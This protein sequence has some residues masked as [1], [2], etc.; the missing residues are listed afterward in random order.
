M[1]FKFVLRSNKIR[2]TDPVNI[3]TIAIL[4][5][6]EEISESVYR[7]G[8]IW[9]FWVI[10]KWFHRKRL[11]K[12]ERTLLCTTGSCVTRWCRCV[13]DEL[14]CVSSAI[15]G[16]IF[17]NKIVIIFLCSERLRSCYKKVK[18][19]AIAFRPVLRSHYAPH[20]LQKIYINC[21]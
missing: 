7:V 12:K 14:H 4:E 19:T 8:T 11:K 10:K 3:C 5:F 20:S 2:I 1:N 15:V 9:F 16:T 17:G 21:H 13:L 6:R 18:T